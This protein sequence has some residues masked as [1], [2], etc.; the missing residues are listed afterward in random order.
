MVTTSFHIIV[1]LPHVSTTPRTVQNARITSTSHPITDNVPPA[2]K[3]YPVTTGTRPSC[4]HDS[5]S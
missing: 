2:P 1:E 3:L 4:R 5:V